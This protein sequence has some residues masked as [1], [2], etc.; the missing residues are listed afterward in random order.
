MAVLILP[1]LPRLIGVIKS[2]TPEM[3]KEAVPR[4]TD[5]FLRG[6]GMPEHVGPE[7]AKR[8]AA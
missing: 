2:I 8:E 3:I 7:K 1:L 4:A 6:C 5:V